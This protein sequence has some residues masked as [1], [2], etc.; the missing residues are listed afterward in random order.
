MIL[1]LWF[2]CVT[3]TR[4]RP[5]LQSVTFVTLFFFFLKASLMASTI[6]KPLQGM[7][8]T[9]MPPN[10]L[11]S[12]LLL[13]SNVLLNNILE[14]QMDAQHLDALSPCQTQRKLKFSTQ[15]TTQIRTDLK[16]NL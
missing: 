15:S 6:N 8:L 12:G 2:F 5:P 13:I 16:C 7:T 3:W 4:S 1:R 9:L 11:T 14:G 10:A